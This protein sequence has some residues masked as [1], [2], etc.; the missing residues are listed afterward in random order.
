MLPNVFVV[1]GGVREILRTL[2]VTKQAGRDSPILFSMRSFMCCPC[3][4]GAEEN[5]GFSAA[6]YGA[7]VRLEVVEDVFPIACQTLRG[8]VQVGD[9]VYFQA[10][11]LVMPVR[12]WWQA[13]HVKGLPSAASS[14]R[15][16]T[17]RRPSLMAEKEVEKDAKVA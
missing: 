8:V 1:F 16:G 7:K 9:K 6:L 13:K 14:G 3:L 11:L 17:R 15:G 5:L 2:S 4:A 12:V 10:A